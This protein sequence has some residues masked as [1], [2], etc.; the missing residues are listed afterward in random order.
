MRFEVKQSFAKSLRKLEKKYRHIRNDLKPVL[1]ELEKNPT[2]G[3]AIP[4]FAN[5]VWKI[6]VS[7]SD[8]QRGK[9][10]SFR[11]IYAMKEKEGIIV[12]LL[13]YAKADREDVK[14]SV[15]KKLLE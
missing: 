8:M 12:L 10:G 15:I 5:L 2:V 11:L 13:I 3:V 9:S 7:S 6:R 1:M 14:V 4:G